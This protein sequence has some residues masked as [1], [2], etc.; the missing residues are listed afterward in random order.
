MHL[1]HKF[2]C[3]SDSNTFLITWSSQEPQ[4]LE[5][6]TQQF[7][8]KYDKDHDGQINFKEFVKYV[9]EHEKDLLS[10]FKKIDTNSDGFVDAGEIV[11]SFKKLGVHIDKKEAEKL[12]Q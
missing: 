7:F 4:G 5:I 11:E 12:L 1:Q 9:K 6:S 2:Y 8:E 10:Y 3:L